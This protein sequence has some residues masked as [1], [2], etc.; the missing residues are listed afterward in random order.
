MLTLHHLEN[1]RSQR[2]LWL[3]E[4]LQCPY[5]LQRYRRDPGNLLAPPELRA[6][7]PLGKSPVLT[8][9]ELVL[10]ESGAI[11]EYL[12]ETRD[13]GQLKPPAG[14]Q[15]SLDYRYWLHYAEGSAMPLLLMSL[16][17]S[18]LDRPPMPWLLRPLAGMIARGVQG[19]FLDPQ[20]KLHLEHVDRHLAGSGWFAGDR[21]SGADIQMSFVLEAAH[22]RVPLARTLPHIGDFLARIHA[23]PAWRAALEKGGAYAYA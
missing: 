8:D 9:G 2:I 16:V 11:V 14:T 23:R 15:A 4:E 5:T 22:S 18:R 1:S 20:L 6:I 21:L 17:F 3:L 13:N 19:R 12:I 10:A 7:H